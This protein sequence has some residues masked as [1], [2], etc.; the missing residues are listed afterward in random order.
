MTLRTLRAG[1][2]TSELW[3]QLAR[4]VD[5]SPSGHPPAPSGHPLPAAGRAASVSMARITPA[6]PR[7]SPARRGR[8]WPT[9]PAAIL[10][11]MDDAASRRPSPRPRPSGAY[12]R[13][14]GSLIACRLALPFS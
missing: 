2:I 6:G 4:R 13:R 11:V 9:G 7:P 1:P 14:H 12:P 10:P 3:G 8:S 5:V